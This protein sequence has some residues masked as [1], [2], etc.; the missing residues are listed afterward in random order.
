VAAARK[1]HF[2][3]DPAEVMG[4]SRLMSGNN[5][6]AEID[7]SLMTSA[8]RYTPELQVRP[9]DRRLAESIN[10]DPNTLL[11]NPEYQ[12]AVSR[13]MYAA[14]FGKHHLSEEA[15]SLLKTAVKG[16]H[17]G[18]VKFADYDS[19]RLKIAY[20]D[21]VVYGTGLN[22]C[23]KKVRAL[24]QIRQFFPD[25][26]PLADN[27]ISLQALL[28]KGVPIPTGVALAEK[29]IKAMTGMS[30]PSLRNRIRV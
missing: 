18:Q 28:D 13:W 3:T 19:K 5:K 21:A 30:R 23:L 12:A 11:V 25:Y 20:A 24:E 14:H 6:S 15:S 17:G 27:I 4:L 1:T 29:I 26:I 9:G 8:G 10:Q 7:S 16:K 2:P 22:K